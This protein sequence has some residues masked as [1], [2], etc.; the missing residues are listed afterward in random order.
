MRAGVALGRAISSWSVMIW[1]DLVAV[2][3]GV[4][5]AGELLL[6]PARAEFIRIAPPYVASRL[7][8]VQ[9]QLGDLATLTGAGHLAAELV[10]GTPRT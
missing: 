7:S 5:A 3:G 6:A 10:S 1:P 8:I 2:A 9:A 4:S